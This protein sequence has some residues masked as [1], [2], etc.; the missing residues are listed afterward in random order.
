MFSGVTQI[1][2]EYELIGS[3]YHVPAKC[4][5][6]AALDAVNASINTSA[7]DAANVVFANDS[8]FVYDQKPSGTSF[9][10]NLAGGPASD[11][12]NIYAWFV[13][14]NTKTVIGKL[15]LASYA[16]QVKNVVII[17]VKQQ[18]P[19]DASVF[20]DYLN[21]TYGRIG[22][23]YQV[24]VDTSFI[25]NTSWDSNGDGV[26]Q[27]TG[28][29]IISNDYQ[30]EEEAMIEAYINSV[31]NIDTTVAYILA[32]YEA[33][34]STNDLLGVMPFQEQFGFLFT[35]VGTEDLFKR[36]VAHELGHGAYYL[37][38]TFSSIYLGSNS[39]G[40][41]NNLMDYAES[42][43]A[44]QLWKYQW[45]IVNAPG[46]VWKIFSEDSEEEAKITP[47]GK[48]CDKFSK[49]PATPIM[50]D[51]ETLDNYLSSMQIS[52]S[53]IVTEPSAGG[54]SYYDYSLYSYSKK[55]LYTLYC[56]SNIIASFY[57]LGSGCVDVSTYNG[58]DVDDHYNSLKTKPKIAFYFGISYGKIFVDGDDALQTL[59]NSKLDTVYGTS[60]TFSSIAVDDRLDCAVRKILYTIGQYYQISDVV[61]VA[62]CVTA[63]SS[64][65]PST[66]INTP[67]TTSPATTS[68]GISQV[69]TIV[70]R[71][72]NVTIKWKVPE[73]DTVSSALTITKLDNTTLNPS[74][75]L[76]DADGF[77]YYSYVE[78]SSICASQ[79]SYTLNVTKLDVNGNATNEF[80]NLKLNTGGF[81]GW[82]F[83]ECLNS[84]VQLGL[85]V[86]GN[87]AS[88]NWTDDNGN[89]IP[90]LNNVSTNAVI[91]NYVVTQNQN[92]KVQR[93]NTDSR[94]V[95]YAYTS[96]SVK[97]CGSTFYLTDATPPD[98]SLN[99]DSRQVTDN[100]TLMVVRNNDTQNDSYSI[101]NQATYGAQSNIVYD[102]GMR[103][104]EGTISWTANNITIP[105]SANLKTVS[106]NTFNKTDDSPY[107]ISVIA[108]GENHSATLQVYNEDVL[109]VEAEN[110]NYNV[111]FQQI[112]TFCKLINAAQE[113]FQAIKLDFPLNCAGP[114]S[115][116]YSYNAE[117]VNSNLVVQDS[118]GEVTLSV[119][120]TPQ[121]KKTF[122]NVPVVGT[123]M[124]LGVSG[125]GGFSFGYDTYHRNPRMK[126]LQPPYSL[127]GSNIMFSLS[128]TVETL[129][130]DW[131][132]TG[133]SS[134]VT[135]PVK[136][137]LFSSANCQ[138]QLQVSLDPIEMS[139][140]A[141]YV[142]SEVKLYEFDLYTPSNGGVFYQNCIIE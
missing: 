139:F 93:T 68:F 15:L 91:S 121:F 94:I 95:D 102:P 69:M 89:V 131:L 117:K 9:T 44:N 128:I 46:H 111:A 4:I 72:Y 79:I 8:G 87:Y 38:H 74:T 104:N 24:S 37:Q 108:P 71:S 33:S 41:T 35:G 105:N 110:V 58:S 54:C 81:Q 126:S 55:V 77:Y 1:E 88:Y 5:T 48:F 97:T 118:S 112:N 64:T 29:N 66:I 36:T 11:A 90:A 124:T 12:Q 73:N 21:Q 100:G 82:F 26:V 70:D 142:G 63:A 62:S 119:M 96:V 57:A 2:Q 45:D 133:I 75:F 130:T 101:V 6:P 59:L 83:S 61:S 78:S 30:G 20:Q 7:A 99:S 28:S 127:N 51:W 98:H 140:S 135:V 129:G 137:N 40:E 134:E 47:K 109:L 56:R 123:E 52:P 39:Q 65:S 136:F 85:S 92:F 84:T 132:E 14:G 34:N 67:V 22:I 60:A 10:I 141:E 32:P 42:V 25:H 43:S 53:P 17:P 3:S 76:V 120:S 19:V 115:V 122:P 125:G 31:T 50:S 49:M 138:L 113:A 106:I 16:P 107:S 86:P 18:L 114:T 13:Q 23:T 27:V 80:E 103:S 116:I